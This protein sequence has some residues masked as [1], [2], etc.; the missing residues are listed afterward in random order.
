MQQQSRTR[1]YLS[2]AQKAQVVEAFKRSGL[3]QRDFAIQEGIAPSNVQRWVNQP[4]GAAKPLGKPQWVEVPNL[5]AGS[6]QEGTYRV[7]FPQ[8]LILEVARPFE[9]EELRALARLL[10]GL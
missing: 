5:V 10:Q 4:S 3:S 7:R 2:P 1:K 9:L 6:G 8:G